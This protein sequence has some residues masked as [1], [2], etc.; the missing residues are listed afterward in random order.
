MI[1]VYT[2]KITPRLTY[3]FKHIFTRIL[4][5]EVEFTTKV[6]IF[7]A[8]KGLKFSYAKQALGNELFIKSSDLLFDQGIDYL[9]IHIVDWSGVPCFF[10]TNTNVEHSCDF[11]AASFYLISRYEEYLPHVKDEFERFPAEES[12]AFQNK[13]LDKPIIDIWA[14]K[15]KNVL[16][17]RFPDFE[18]QLKNKKQFKFLSTIDVDIAFKYKHKGIVRTIGGIVND[19]IHFNLKDIWFRFLVIFNIKKDPFDTFDELIALQKKYNVTTLFFFL[20]SEYTTYDKNVSAGNINYKLLIKNV[21]D[22]AKVGIHPSY[23]SIK[24]ELKLK[25][26]KKRLENIVNFPIK[27]SRQHYLRLDLPETYQNL[28]DI[29]ISEDYTMG[30][31]SHYGFR[32]GTCTPFYFYDIDFEIQ[33]PIKVFPFAVMD[34]TLRDYLNFTPKRSFDIMIKLAEEV[35]KVN[36]TFITLFHNESVSGEDRWRGWKKLYENLLKELSTK[37]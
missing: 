18:N 25:K 29:E 27:K 5:I 4:G 21:A 1:L 32:A 20:L 2:H 13:F 9:D 14:Y 23:F 10:Q 31:A 17:Q 36:G 7:I 12:I 24:N 19:L 26:E 16:L 28:V 34:G 15:F 22:Y 35:K 30:Y 33:T 8:H 6:E 37:D 11:F 3:T